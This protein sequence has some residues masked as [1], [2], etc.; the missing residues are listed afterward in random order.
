MAG[1]KKLG[2]LST[3]QVIR[4]A[5]TITNPENL[6]QGYRVISDYVSNKLAPKQADY[7]RARTEAWDRASAPELHAYLQAQE[8]YPIPPQ[9]RP[10]RFKLKGGEVALYNPNLHKRHSTMP[11]QRTY[12]RSGTGGRMYP[13]GTYTKSR[14]YPRKGKGGYSLNWVQGTRLNQRTG[15]FQG[16][17][18]KWNDVGKTATTIPGTWS[19][20][21]TVDTFVAMEQNSSETGRIGRKI[22]W[23]MMDIW[24]EVTMPKQDITI[25]YQNI[26]GEHVHVFAALV[27]DKQCNKAAATPSEVY[28]SNTPNQLKLRN[29]EFSK[30]FEVLWRKQVVWENMVPFK[31]DTSDTAN[32]MPS[33]TRIIHKITKLYKRNITTEYNSSGTTV[34]TVNTNNLF[35]LLFQN[36]SYEGLCTY[37]IRSRF[38]YIG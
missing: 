34:A 21:N 5:Q 16:V 3:D 7:R 25:T 22:R 12:P 32:R 17:E 33:R 1:W 29:L 14:T 13:R 10:V 20:S 18:K 9:V 8:A 15:G 27:W 31:I 38:R 35:L 19:S 6:R 24:L 37:Q 11:F 2:K 26:E 28:L 4:A 36:T 23:E 30:R